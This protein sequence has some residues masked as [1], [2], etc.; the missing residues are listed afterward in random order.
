MRSIGKGDHNQGEGGRLGGLRDWSLSIG[1]GGYKTGGGQ[2]KFYPYK[3]G[4]KKF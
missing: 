4:W 3:S 2:K 1:S